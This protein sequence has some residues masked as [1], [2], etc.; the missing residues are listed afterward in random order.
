MIKTIR[1]AYKF[2][3]KPS[4]QDVSTM[5]SFAGSNR[6]VYNKFLHMNLQRLESKQP[7]LW[8]NEM[9]FWLTLWKKTEEYCFLKTIHSQTLQQ[10]LKN[11][12][13]AFKEGFDKNQPIKK[14]P[15]FKKKGMSDSFRYPQG[16]KLDEAAKSIYLPKI[17]W[18]KYHRSRKITGDIKNVTVSRRGQHWYVSIQVQTEQKM[19]YHPSN[20]VIGVD[21]GITRF[22]TL[23]NGDYIEPIHSFRVLE[24]KLATAQRRL[25]KKVK[26]SQNWGKQKQRITRLHEKIANAR[27]DFLH[28]TSTQLSKNHAIIVVED[29][30]VKNMSKSAT[31]TIENKGKNVKAKSGL[32]KSI[33]DQGWSLFVTLL[34][35]KQ[36][37]A[38]GQVIKVPAAYTS[39]CCPACKH[40]DKGNRI[41]QADFKCVSCAYS[42]HADKVGAINVLERGHRLLACGV[43]T[44]VSTV[45]QEPELNREVVLHNGIP[46]L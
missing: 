9:A 17:G 14:M 19:P 27:L 37:W 22:L 43:D 36:D 31:G 6:F 1:K 28:K 25:S 33:L 10:T 23:S 2:R 40:I 4:E 46:I 29:L 12:E 8:Y 7:L 39:Q 45:K 3:L 42:E 26:F 15:T 38:G 24:K 41:K 32:N 44:L 20:D 11:L 13:R 30:N 21:L 35:Y 5:L 16:V 34:E 18:V